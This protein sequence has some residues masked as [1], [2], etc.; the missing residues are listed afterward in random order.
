MIKM[1]KYGV[2]DV[3]GLELILCGFTVRIICIIS[4]Y[5]SPCVCTLCD[6]LVKK[7]LRAAEL[8]DV[9]SNMFLKY[10]ELRF[11]KKLRHNC[12]LQKWQKRLYSLH[13]FTE[14]D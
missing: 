8:D 3:T 9:A 4:L 11:S 1:N 10:A 13:G 6:G 2:A 14:C 5:V 12:G 7:M